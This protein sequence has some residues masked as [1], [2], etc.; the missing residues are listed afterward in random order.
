MHI[1]V[2]QSSELG[3][4]ILE[5]Q[6]PLWPGS[7]Y[8]SPTRHL[9]FFPHVERVPYPFKLPSVLDRTQDFECVAHMLWH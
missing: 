7:N 5:S 4:H 3:N 6:G 1:Q 9:P 2:L 8:L